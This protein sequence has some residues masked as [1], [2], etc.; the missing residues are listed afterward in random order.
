MQLC[1]HE[2]FIFFNC[3]SAL[4][5]TFCQSGSNIF[6]L[7]DLEDI[8]AAAQ[9][10]HA[11]YSLATD[12]TLWPVE[13]LTSDMAEGPSQ[14][15]CHTATRVDR[16]RVILFGGHCPLPGTL[17]Q[18]SCNLF[19]PPRCRLFQMRQRSAFSISDTSGILMIPESNYINDVKHEVW[20]YNLSTAFSNSNRNTIRKLT[21][22]FFRAR[23]ET[24]KFREHIPPDLHARTEHAA[25]AYKGK[26]IVVGGYA[27]ALGYSSSVL[28]FDPGSPTPSRALT[29]IPHNRV[30]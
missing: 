23:T 19:Q 5:L 17:S 24:G 21:S 6:R 22:F 4:R 12:F 2:F 25:V 9:V 3:Y 27:G 20:E 7:L 30:I 15:V 28:E 1:V 16:E 14:R 26:V 13:S 11:W 18:P 8:A 29:S 10:C